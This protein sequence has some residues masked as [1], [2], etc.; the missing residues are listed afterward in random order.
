MADAAEPV[1]TQ[2]SMLLH[3]V[4]L[5]YSATAGQLPLKNDDGETEG[6][7][8]FVAYTKPGVPLG[9]RPI[10]FATCAPWVRVGLS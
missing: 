8:F 9:T 7:I 4:K 6:R 5:D 1:V 10:T 3:G 2:H